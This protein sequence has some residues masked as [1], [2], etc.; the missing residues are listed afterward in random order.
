MQF[1]TWLE[2]YTF[3]K[4]ILEVS[5][6]TLE[7]GGVTTN[8]NTYQ[9]LDPIDAWGLPKYPGKTAILLPEANIA[10]ELIRFIQVNSMYLQ[11]PDV[12]LGTWINPYTRCCHLDITTIYP[13]LE[14]AKRE[15]FLRS[16]Q[17]SR[18]IVAVYNFKQNQTVYLG[19]EPA[20]DEIDRVRMSNMV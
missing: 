13:T 4:Y 6:A 18:S 19:G 1:R 11:E 15:A 9:F 3:E 20:G 5:I 10:E 12:W 17:E 7:R 2:Q 14:E 8:P 16:M